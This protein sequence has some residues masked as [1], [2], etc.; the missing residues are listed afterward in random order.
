V[1]DDLAG[2]HVSAFQIDFAAL[3]VT[4]SRVAAAM[5][6]TAAGDAD[7]GQGRAVAPEPYRS[8]IQEAIGRAPRHCDIQAG[9]RLFPPGRLSLERSGFHLEGVWFGAERVISGG[10]AGST[11]LVLFTATAGAAFDDWIRTCFDRNDLVTGFLIDS[12]GSEVAECAADWIERRIMD[13]ARDLG[14]GCTNR[15]SPGYCGWP[16]EDQQRLFS[17]LPE[18][19]CGVSLTSTALMLPMKSVSGVIGIGPGVERKDY[20]CRICDHED[21]YRRRAEFVE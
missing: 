17:F 16:V 7:T 4:P 8:M 5:G 18:H 2:A 12:L 9:Y 1:A 15:F 14:L 21:C 11:G 13:A 20:Q 19:F 3:E 6:Y 10:L